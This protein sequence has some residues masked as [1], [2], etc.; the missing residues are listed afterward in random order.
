MALFTLNYKKNFVWDESVSSNIK[1][2][3]QRK[4][5]EQYRAFM[6]SLRKGKEKAIHV[7]NAVW[8]IRREAWNSLEFKA[9][10][11]KATAN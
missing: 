2:V 4:V 11:E 6:C 10:S 1:M 5:A 9:R 8:E 3:W 7:S